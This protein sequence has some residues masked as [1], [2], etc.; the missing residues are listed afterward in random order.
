[1]NLSSSTLEMVAFVHRK[2]IQ[3]NMMG[4]CSIHTEMIVLT[5]GMNPTITDKT[6]PAALDLFFLM[7]PAIIKLSAQG[8]DPYSTSNLL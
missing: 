5:F 7:L 4:F 8:A 2:V 3:S 1:M 6:S